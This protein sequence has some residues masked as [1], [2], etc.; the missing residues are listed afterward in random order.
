MA[1][2]QKLTYLCCFC[3]AV[4]AL[5]LLWG[6]YLVTILYYGKNKVNKLT[7]KPFWVAMYG[8]IVKMLIISLVLCSGTFEKMKNGEYDWLYKTYQGCESALFG[9]DYVL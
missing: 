2:D 7:L 3:M 6:A 5:T 1:L 9:A 8:S 4:S